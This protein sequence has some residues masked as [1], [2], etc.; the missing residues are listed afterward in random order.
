MRVCNVIYLYMCVMYVCL[1]R[2]IYLMYVCNA[3]NV[4]YVMCICLKLGREEYCDGKGIGRRVEGEEKHRGKLRWRLGEIE[5]SGGRESRQKE[6][7]VVVGVKVEIYFT[8]WVKKSV[9]FKYFINVFCEINSAARDMFTCRRAGWKVRAVTV[10]DC[11]QYSVITQH[12]EVMNRPVTDVDFVEGS[13]Q[14]I[15]I[16]QTPSA[17]FIIYNSSDPFWRDVLCASF[18]FPS[19]LS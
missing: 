2:C 4:I 18:Q 17:L 7:E 5:G 19:P 1:Y 6:N 16:N 8:L 10:V 15:K 14:F 12:T 13:L 9:F 3:C 11:E